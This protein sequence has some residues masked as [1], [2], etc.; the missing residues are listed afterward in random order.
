MLHLFAL[1]CLLCPVARAVVPPP[2]GG[3][4]GNNTAEGQNALLSLTTGTFNTAVG[5]LSLKSDTTG[6]GNT[7]VGAGTLFANVADQNT[8]TG[9]AALLSNTTGTQN[10]ADGALTLL[11]N[12][13][14]SNNTA[15]GAFALFDNTTGQSNT[16]VGELA[17]NQN[18]TGNF[19]TAVGVAALALAA[20]NS[21]TAVGSGAGGNVLSAS[22]V[23]CIG[24]GVIGTNTDNSCYIG[25]I[26]NQ[27]GGSQA[28]YVNSDGKLGA[29]VSSRRFK[30]NI[31]SMDKISNALFSLHPV[32][33]RYKR[34][35]DPEGMSQCGLVAED[36]EKVDPDLVLH[37]KEG[38]PYSV[39]Y[40]QVNAMVLNEFLKEH[41]KV[42]ELEA[43][44][45]R[46]AKKMDALADQIKEQN[47]YIQR[48]GAQ[49]QVNHVPK[50]VL[51]SSH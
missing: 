13:T 28:V 21:N 20:G 16:A 31:E 4:P 11:N 44:M 33:F 36:V 41:R 12:R 2:D 17:L 26:W 32:S 42:Q 37:D 50:T 46:Q 47:A 43:A 14:G 10:T 40:D 49:V 38:K 6:S 51:F 5:S 7:A 19:N 48:V 27:P 15:N 1:G 8:A 18:Q 25:S 22:N 35:I 45:V 39:R 9:V 29:L 24:Q 3:Y 34:E 30:D 23:I